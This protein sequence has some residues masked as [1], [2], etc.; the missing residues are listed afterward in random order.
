MTTEVVHSAEEHSD[1]PDQKKFAIVNVIG[2][3][4]IHYSIHLFLVT[5]LE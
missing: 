3:C 5:S 1:V 2:M 4:H